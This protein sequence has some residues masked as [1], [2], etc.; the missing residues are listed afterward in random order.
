[1]NELATAIEQHLGRKITE[2][3]LTYYSLIGVST[4][5]STEEVRVALKTAVANWNASNTKAD[6]ESAKLV[7]SLL[8]QAQTV[9][10]DVNKKKEYDNQL[11]AKWE[12]V[13][14][15]AFP[16]VD[17]LLPF[18]PADCT[19]GTGSISISNAFGSGEERWLELKRHIPLLQELES[20]APAPSVSVPPVF[21]LPQ[22]IKKQSSGPK[23]KSSL[24][25]VEQ[26]KRKR[27]NT[28]RFYI[29]GFVSVALL[30]LAY[31]VVQFSLNRF[32]VVNHLDSSKGALNGQKLG[33]ESSSGQARER[34][35]AGGADPSS[36]SGLPSVAR[37]ETSGPVVAGADEMVPSM[38]EI[39][40]PSPGVTMK[41]EA[42]KDTSMN[43]LETEPPRTSKT[44]ASAANGKEWSAAMKKARES[45]E[46][47][48]FSNFHRQMELA[49][50]I[51]STEEMLAK[52]KRLDQ[53]GQLYEI[54]LNSLKSAKSKLKAG[55]VVSVGKGKVS[56]VE[57]QDSVL[58]VKLQGKNERYSW[59]KLPPGIAVAM[60]DLTLSNEAPS[61][62][63]AR[64]VYFSLSPARNELSA[65]KAKEWFE[66]SVGNGEIRADLTQ[67]LTDTYE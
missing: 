67:A 35:N 32:Q 52:F 20:N 9:L 42:A 10:L 22:S 61:D 28:Q 49:L 34:T 41:S 60:A 26:L 4:Q 24:S 44:P 36:P 64:A 2:S 11:L 3:E 8:K 5:A 55:D 46:S 47:A 7:A 66:K 58:I 15:S 14:D 23:P 48:D 1:M 6:P 16:G 63:A 40:A 45:L 57:I 31:A 33:L 25:R 38:V 39:P 56:I 62:L 37:E 18:D 65:N 29:A 12:F 17:P 19:V 50:P 30:F 53:L 21:D 13:F 54:C 43:M 27:Q 59:D 51:S